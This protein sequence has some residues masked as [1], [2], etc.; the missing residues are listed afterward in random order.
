M[1]AWTIPYTTELVWVLQQSPE[2]LDAE[3]RF[4]LAIR[5]YDTGKLNTYVAAQIAGLPTINFVRLLRDHA[6]A[7]A[8]AE[9]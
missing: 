1:S 6:L 9:I 4:Q 5:L 8:E 7:A 2:T 3:A